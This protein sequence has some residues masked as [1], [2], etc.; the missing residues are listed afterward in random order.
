MVKVPLFRNK[1]DLRVYQHFE[2]LMGYSTIQYYK[3][4]L[5]PRSLNQIIPFTTSWEIM[6]HRCRFNTQNRS[7]FTNV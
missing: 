4:K 1:S 5:P 7:T 6:L 2:K 3:N